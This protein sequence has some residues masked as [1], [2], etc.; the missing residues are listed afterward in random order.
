VQLDALRA[1]VGMQ[2]GEY[3]RAATFDRLPPSVPPIN[4]EAAIELRG[5][6]NNINQYQHMINL[7]VATY[8]PRELLVHLLELLTAVRGQLRGVS[9]TPPTPSPQ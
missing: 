1:K 9:Q 7:G 4:L 2:R 8:Y 5:L 6:A 3:M